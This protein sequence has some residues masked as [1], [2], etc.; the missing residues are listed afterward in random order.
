MDFKEMLE[1]ARKERT[2]IEKMPLRFQMEMCEKITKD[3]FWQYVKVQK[4]GWS[5]YGIETMF[6]EKAQ[7]KS[8]LSKGKY[9]M[10]IKYYNALSQTH[11][12]GKDL[13]TGYWRA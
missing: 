5:G 2:A 1:L 6:S 7:E 4:Q 12:I 3:E 9:I 13:R 11:G 8:G 10:C